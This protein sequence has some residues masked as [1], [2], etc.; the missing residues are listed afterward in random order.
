MIIIVVNKLGMGNHL[1]SKPY[2]CDQHLRSLVQ[3]YVILHIINALCLE[4]PTKTALLIIFQFIKL[5]DD[6]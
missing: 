6:F 5:L 3:S 2:Y 4:A 1:Q